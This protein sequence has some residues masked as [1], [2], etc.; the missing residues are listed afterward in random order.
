M[1][2]LPTR[3]TDIFQQEPWEAQ[4]NG[5]LCWWEGQLLIQCPDCGTW[6]VISDEQLHGTQ[7]FDCDCG[8]IDIRDWHRTATYIAYRYGPQP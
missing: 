6:G 3:Q 5:H 4:P 1:T 8:F 7:P 2:S